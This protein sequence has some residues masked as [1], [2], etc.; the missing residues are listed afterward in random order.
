MAIKEN[1]RT[2]N[3]TLILIRYWHKVFHKIWENMCEKTPI[4]AELGQIYCFN[5][6]SK[7]IFCHI[8]GVFRYFN[9]IFPDL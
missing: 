1:F 2:I 8:E 4:F 9:Y 6:D 5:K 7:S 3:C